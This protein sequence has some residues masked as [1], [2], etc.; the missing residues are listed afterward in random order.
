MNFKEALVE[1]TAVFFNLDE[2][3]ET[4]NIDGTDMPI[5]IDSDKLEELKSS[6]VNDFE[7]V[8]KAQLLFYVKKSDFGG[9]PAIDSILNMDDK[10][11]R[12][13]AS[14]ENGDM[15]TILLGWYED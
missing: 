14:S 13:V 15:L 4:H 1:D 11:Y 6:R 7:G 9:K 2:F 5:I 3:A 12:V 8:Y 10:T